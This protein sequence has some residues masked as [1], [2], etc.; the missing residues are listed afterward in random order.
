M[1]R[2]RECWT[3]RLTALVVAL[4]LAAPVMA[5]T[6]ATITVGGSEQ[7]INGAWDQA[8]IVVSFNNFSESVTYGQFSSAAAVASALAG[9]FSRDYAAVGLS[10]KASCPPSNAVIT[11]TLQGTATFGALSIG[12]PTTSFQF[13]NPSGF[14]SVST[15]SS[16]DPEITGLSLK[17]GPVQ[18]GLVITGTNFGSNPSVKL[19]GA[20][21]TIISPGSSSII[22]QVPTGA[23]SGNI[24]V[25]NG[26]DSNGVPFKVDPPFGCN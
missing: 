12:N 19:N 11:F 6:T 23:T 1:L 8:T 20:T 13:L 24:V 7:Q 18:M 25:T 3:K 26:V 16:S 17:E 5:S 10:A 15:P 14:T 2:K 9:M 4:G 21:M 22:V